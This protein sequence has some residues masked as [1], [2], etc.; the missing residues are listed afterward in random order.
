MELL[1]PT[2]LRYP[3]CL[4]RV[5]RAGQLRPV[6]KRM[7]SGF[8]SK[9]D[10]QH[11]KQEAYGYG[12]G[13]W[14]TSIYLHFCFPNCTVL[15][16]SYFREKDPRFK[17]AL[18]IVGKRGMEVI[19]DIKKLNRTNPPDLLV[20]PTI[21]KFFFVEVKKDRDK[22]RPTQASAFKNIAAKLGC[23]VKLARLKMITELEDSCMADECRK[24]FEKCVRRKSRVR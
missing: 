8:F 20:Q 13:D 1:D 16:R 4:L 23:K 9:A 7:Y 2:P 18:E 15:R 3:A 22:L 24:A 10:L 17:I 19:R 21:G 6:W 5:W 12:F 14:F 11:R